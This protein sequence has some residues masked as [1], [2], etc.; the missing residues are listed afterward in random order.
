M[1][2][3][4]SPG[5][6][7][8]WSLLETLIATKPEAEYGLG[9]EF[10]PRFDKIVVAEGRPGLLGRVYLSRDLAYVDCVD[11]AWTESNLT[12]RFSLEHPE[13]L[14][15][16]RSYSQAPHIGSSR[17]FNAL[18]PAMLTAFELT[19]LSDRELDNLISKLLIVGVWHQRGQAL[20][21]ALTNREIKHA[22]TVGPP[23]VRQH[24]SWTFWRMMGEE[25]AELPDRATRWRQFIG[26]F[27]RDVWPL[28]VAL[29]SEE[30]TRNLVMM[31][32]ECAAVFPE[33]VD[34]IL[35]LV[36][37]YRLYQIAHSLRL[38]KEHDELV[39]EHPLPFVRLTN[40]LR[41]S[42]TSVRYR[43]QISVAVAKMASAATRTNKVRP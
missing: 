5:G 23:G 17:L 10:K 39:R 15:M 41:R 22:L 25:N 9:P 29:R 20:D 36:V 3:L 26:P 40:A 8:A 37:P 34:A 4:N 18:K 38:Q 42:P 11:P 6:I 33:A 7:L 19:G 21:Y 32:L 14:A 2:S 31:A 30:T 28:D 43:P 16:W 35:D 24:A 12:P 13:A 1:E 27:F